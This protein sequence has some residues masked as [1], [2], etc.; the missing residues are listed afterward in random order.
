MG[1]FWWLLLT[2]VFSFW[3]RWWLCIP[4]KPRWSFQEPDRPRFTSQYHD[5]A[6][7][8]ESLLLGSLVY[9]VTKDQSHSCNGG[10]PWRKSESSCSRAPLIPLVNE[11]VQSTHCVSLKPDY[12]NQDLNFKGQV[13]LSSNMGGKH[14]AVKVKDLTLQMHSNAHSLN[15]TF[16]RWTT[17]R[18]SVRDH[19]V[20]RVRPTK[21]LVRPHSGP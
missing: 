17:Q 9:Y 15:T 20:G 14:E 19:T 21:D 3:Q 8:L 12:I 4:E 13:P 11:H 6:H 1:C 7:N 5:S 18:M 10:S 16:R 2:H